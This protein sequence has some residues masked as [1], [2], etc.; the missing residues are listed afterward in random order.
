M[1]SPNQ[2]LLNILISIC[3]GA[4]ALRILLS[5]SQHLQIPQTA[6]S[7]L[8]QKKIEFQIPFVTHGGNMLV[9]KLEI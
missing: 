4:S 9:G 5:F 8:I 1:F 2:V 7:K 6:I 3:K